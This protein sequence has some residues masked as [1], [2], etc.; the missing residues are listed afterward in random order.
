MTPLTDLL[1][2]F[3]YDPVNDWWGLKLT[4]LTFIKLSNHYQAGAIAD[5]T[6]GLIIA[7]ATLRLF[8]VVF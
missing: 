8:V 1:K 7:D 4:Y 5:G 6:F 2:I 3:G